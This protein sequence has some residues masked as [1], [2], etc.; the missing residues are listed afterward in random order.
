MEVFAP[1]S[2]N[3]VKADDAE[4]CEAKRSTKLI[5]TY[6]ADHAL[7]RGYQLDTGLSVRYG[8]ISYSGFPLPMRGCER[9]VVRSWLELRRYPSLHILFAAWT[10]AE[11]TFVRMITRMRCGEVVAW[12]SIVSREGS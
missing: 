4:A 1:T 3:N 9:N 7:I 2:T 12:L 10:W 5:S 8:V 6:P 11:V